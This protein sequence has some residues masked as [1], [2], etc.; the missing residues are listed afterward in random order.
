M[1]KC[2][3]AWRPSF[4]RPHPSQVE[5]E[6]YGER[7]DASHSDWLDAFHERT[8]I[9]NVDAELV[10]V[11]AERDAIADVTGLIVATHDLDSSWQGVA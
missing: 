2:P 4:R 5:S 10:H 3:I 8:A 1:S 11:D 7:M 9:L 6:A